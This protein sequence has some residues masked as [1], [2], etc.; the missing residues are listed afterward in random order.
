MMTV[1]INTSF[2]VSDIKSKSFM[3]TERIKDP[4]DRYAVRAAEE[5]EAEVWQALQES[6]RSL[7]TLCRPF[8][9]STSDTAGNDTLSISSTNK[10]LQFDLSERRTSNI[11]DSLAQAIHSYLSNGTLRR[12]YTSAAMADLMG[13]YAQGETAARDEIVILLY[14]K[15][16]PVYSA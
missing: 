12:F 11:G 2:L 3:N 16:E 1:T 15:S 7:M 14:K 13:M 9:A 8:L 4:D 10:T 5:N 6:W